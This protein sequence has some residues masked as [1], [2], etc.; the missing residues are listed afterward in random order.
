[1]E[2]TC[3]VYIGLY[4][5]LPYHKKLQVPLT[6]IMSQDDTDTAAMQKTIAPKLCW[7]ADQ[8]AG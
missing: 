1:M 8:N 7:G 3:P 4:Q 5:D 2:T 6:V